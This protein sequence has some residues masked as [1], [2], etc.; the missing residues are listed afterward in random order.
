LDTLDGIV[1]SQ[2]EKVAYRLHH[3]CLDN[4][5]DYDDV[6]DGVLEREYILHLCPKR[7][8]TE[9]IPAEK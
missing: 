6:I 8:E 7:E 5:Y 4:G 9:D 2:P 3:L 1:V